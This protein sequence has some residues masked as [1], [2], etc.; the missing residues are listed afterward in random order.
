V[1]LG[2]GA[3]MANP[4]ERGDVTP[5]PVPQGRALTSG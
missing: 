5:Q 2:R 3:R 1:P 4:F